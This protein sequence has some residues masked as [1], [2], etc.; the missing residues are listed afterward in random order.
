MAEIFVFE[1]P[2]KLAPVANDL[3]V[4]GDSEDTDVDGKPKRKKAKLGNIET[5]SVQSLT[6]AALNTLI[7]AS[8]LVV[9]AKYLITDATTENISIIVEAES[10]NTLSKHCQLVGDNFDLMEY[11]ISTDIFKGI[12]FLTG[13]LRNTGGTWDFI[14]DGGHDK[15]NFLSASTVADGVVVTYSRDDY[16]TTLSFVVTPDETYAQLG[17]DCGASVGLQQAQIFLS[18]HNTAYALLQYNGATWDILLGRGVSA[19]SFNAG[20]LT[21]THTELTQPTNY[22][23]TGRGGVYIPQHISSSTNQTVISFY[24]YTG[25]IVN[26]ENTDMKVF[27][28][29]SSQKTLATA[30]SAIAGSNLWVVAQMMKQI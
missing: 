10:T 27:F 14:T 30:E 7:T 23:L 19:A 24:D 3:I 15:R 9:G 22:Q 2:E 25:A 21:I 17:V 12:D 5:L 20:Q 6:Y 28:N 26:S 16:N 1:N 18:A 13:V 4:I 11:D 8:E 29:A